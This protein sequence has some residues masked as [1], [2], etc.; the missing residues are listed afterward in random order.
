[1]INESMKLRPTAELRKGVVPLMLG[2][3]L[4]VSSIV[5]MKLMIMSLFALVSLIASKFA[6]LLAFATGLLQNNSGHATKRIVAISAGDSYIPSYHHG[7]SAAHFSSDGGTTGFDAISLGSN[8]QATVADDSS[9]IQSAHK[10][11]RIHN[12]YH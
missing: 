8:T 12:M 6:L 7:S 2:V 11:R 10:R 4:K 1:M 9:I 5:P 3:L